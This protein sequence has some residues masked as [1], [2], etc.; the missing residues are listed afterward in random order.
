MLTA[1]TFHKGIE[2]LESA[3]AKEV[4]K[5]ALK[6]WKEM[7][8]DEGIKDSDFINGVKVCCKS[9]KFSPSVGI[10]IEY[11][12]KEK[13]ERWRE[14]REKEKY[15]NRE[16]DKKLLSS[17]AASEMGR[18]SIKLI[19]LM[20]SGKISNRQKID[21]MLKMEEFYPGVGWQHEAMALK[22]YFESIDRLEE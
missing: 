11:C 8:E 22:N 12:N 9:E 21:Y 17:N 13:M 14:E 5:G 6:I 4:H 18:R 10:L 7:I 19:Q 15:V 2:I 3:F 20:L 16:T 1:K